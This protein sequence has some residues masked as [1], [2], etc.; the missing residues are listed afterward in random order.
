MTP[1][2]R[3][4]GTA[5]RDGGQR[6]ASM[7]LLSRLQ[8]HALDTDYH[9]V[10]SR[11]GGGPARSRRFL[12]TL[13][14][15]AFGALLATAAVQAQRSA[16]AIAEERAALVA[17][18]QRRSSGVEAL[19]LRVDRLRQRVE[20]LRAASTVARSSLGSLRER[21]EFLALAAGASAVSGPGVRIVIDDAP[22]GSAA[23]PSGTV[24]DVDLQSIVNGLWAAGAEAVAIDGHRLSSLSAIR[25]AGAAI[26]VNYASLTPPYAIEAIGNPNTLPASLLETSAGQTMLDLEANFGLR[27][28]VYTKEQ[29]DL[30]ADRRLAR[31]CRH[32]EAARP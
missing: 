3:F 31:C 22:S 24:V 1:T 21:A 19:R 32:A 6:A 23:G 28:D 18:I 15:V 8:G 17:H 16:P 29:L 30:P 10:A 27:F 7:S 12:A 11:A 20:S 13:V 14:V 5:G 4:V 26:T 25:G 9:D 2:Q